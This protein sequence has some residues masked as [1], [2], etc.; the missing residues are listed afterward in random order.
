MNIIFP[1][2][3]YVSNSAS[4]SF[5]TTSGR[6]WPPGVSWNHI[7]LHFIIIWNSVEFQECGLTFLEDDRRF[8]IYLN[9]KF[10]FI[11]QCSMCITCMEAS[12]YHCTCMD[13]RG[14]LLVISSLFAL[15]VWVWIWVTR[16]CS[17][18][19]YQLSQLTR[20]IIFLTSF[21]CRF[22]HLHFPYTWSF[23]NGVG[24]VLKTANCSLDLLDLHTW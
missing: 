21:I 17:K 23:G 11:S 15:W 19:C 10:Y 18:Q 6:E 22:T 13:V 2:L 14:K 1:F 12:T 8:I 4:W 9:F 16:L 24:M 3:W 5:L 7:P 20:V